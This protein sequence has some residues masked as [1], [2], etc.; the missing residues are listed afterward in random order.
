MMSPFLFFLLAGFYKLLRI[1]K[2]ESADIPKLCASL[3]IGFGLGYI[4]YNRV[5]SILTIFVIV[6][7]M[8]YQTEPLIYLYSDDIYNREVNSHSITKFNAAWL[9]LPYVLGAGLVVFICGADDY[10][11]YNQWFCTP[12]QWVRFNI[13]SGKSADIFGYNKSSTYVNFILDMDAVCTCK[14]LIIVTL[15][16]WLT[17]RYEF[18]KLSEICTIFHR[19]C[20]AFGFI[21]AL[22]SMVGHKELRFLHDLFLI[23]E[24]C[25][26]LSMTILW[27]SLIINVE[28]VYCNF[29]STVV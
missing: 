25:F 29:K 24:L 9:L 12:L 20:L 15:F 6:A 7:V 14:L 10:Y 13:V 4:C 23:M 21:L 27:D 8:L 16:G 17:S 2:T 22:Y 19:L 3:L 26:C 1:R 5:D 18:N 11:V 28:Q